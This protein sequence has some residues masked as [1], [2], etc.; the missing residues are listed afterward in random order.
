MS[1]PIPVTD[2]LAMP[3]GAI[4]LPADGSWPNAR[5]MAVAALVEVLASR[6]VALPLGPATA[7]QEDG[8]LLSLNRFALQLSTSG[9]SADQIAI[10]LTPWSEQASAPQL[11]LSALV[12]EENALV[13]FGGVLT[14]PEF[15]S[16]ASTAERDGDQLLLDVDAFRGGVER[17]LTLVQLL[18]PEALPRTA[19]VSW[20]SAGAVVSAVADW[21]QGRLDEGLSALGGVLLPPAMQPGLSAGGMRSSAAAISG[22]E[23]SIPLAV[24][25]IPLGLTPDGQL[26]SGEEARQCVET[27]QLLLIPS[28]GP[29][30]GD[31]PEA[32]VLQLTGTI[33]GDLLPDGIELIAEQGRLRQSATSEQSNELSL[34]FRGVNPIQVVLRTAAGEPLQLPLLQLPPQA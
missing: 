23:N 21:L 4:E 9:I 30:A 26:V 27:F 32:L 28:T 11:L 33:T 31:S 16:L 3:P 20:R 18:E 10:D 24:L 14:G 17:L 6:G 2:V 25:A 22:L 34:C 15:V 1:E 12:D 13:A 8:R 29:G 19:L 7:A 5:A